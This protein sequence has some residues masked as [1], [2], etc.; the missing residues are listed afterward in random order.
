MHK[1]EQKLE[2]QYIV[3]IALICFKTFHVVHVCS[4]YS[5]FLKRL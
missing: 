5:S 4:G 2:K 1:N 3:K